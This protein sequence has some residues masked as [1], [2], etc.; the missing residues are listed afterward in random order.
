MQS[1]QDKK[2]LKQLQSLREY[3]LQKQLLK[4]NKHKNMLYE[5]EQEIQTLVTH[6]ELLYKRRLQSQ[7]DQFTGLKNTTI[8]VDDL[9]SY[10]N[11]ILQLKDEEDAELKK[12]DNTHAKIKNIKHEIEKQKLKVKT[13]NK[14]VESL[15]VLV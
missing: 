13:L 8:S 12:L 6:A 10:R 15:K 5:Y 2:N 9:S 4:L 1:Q 14:K 3:K 11:S 7:E